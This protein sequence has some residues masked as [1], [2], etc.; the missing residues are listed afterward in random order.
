MSTTVAFQDRFIPDVLAG[1]K[2][3]TVRRYRQEKAYPRVG[4]PLLLARLDG[5][6]VVALARCELIQRCQI[7]AG[8][9]VRLHPMDGPEAEG[10]WP[11]GVYE[12]E[13]FARRDG[14]ANRRAMVTWLSDLYGS[15]PIDGVVLRWG[16]VERVALGG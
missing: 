14:F 10:W 1:V 2:T 4:D 9:L 15:L 6:T 11:I 7:D 16:E 13:R 3:Q 8:G 5:E 12:S